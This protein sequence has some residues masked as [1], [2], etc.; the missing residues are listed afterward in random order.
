MKY[1]WRKQEKDYYLP[2][3]K[4]VLIGIPE[5]RYITISGKGNPNGKGFSDR[6]GVLYP[7]A[8]GI[9][10]Q[11]KKYCRS[12]EDNLP[13]YDDYVVFPLEAV[14]DQTEA[15]RKSEE[16]NK[17]ELV[18]DMMMK[19][20]DFIP[21]EMIYQALAQIKEKKPHELLDQVK[22][23]KIKNGLAVQ[24]LH[25]GSY[26]DEPESFKQMTAFCD[27]APVKRN[28]HWHREIYLTDAR[29]TM[30]EKAKT[31]LRYDVSSCLAT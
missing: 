21:D 3:T 14:W 27:E 10:M 6:I 9:K 13:E 19:I 31:I 29:K 15:G 30:P 25:K 7:V 24:M 8:Y 5:S 16:L 20:P 1:E 2:K 11:Y 22:I 26:D 4:P 23:K 17:D 28:S 18:Y 12:L